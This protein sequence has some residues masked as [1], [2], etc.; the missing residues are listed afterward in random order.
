[1]IIARN[2]SFVG[3][4]LHSLMDR[5]LTKIFFFSIQEG[6]D[7]VDLRSTREHFF[8]IGTTQIV[9]GCLQDYGYAHHQQFLK[10]N[11]IHGGTI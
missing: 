5:F 7:F 9:S 1:M 11:E 2:I 4:N 3:N 6:M 8:H 10:R